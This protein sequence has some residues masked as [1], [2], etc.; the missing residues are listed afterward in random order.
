MNL[1]SGLVQYHPALADLMVDIDAVTQHPDNNNN[2]DVDQ[3][4]TSIEVNG[5][6]RPIYAQRATKYIVAG[7]TTWE[8]CK[9]LGAQLIPVIWLDVDDIAAL[10]ILLADNKIAAL[11]VPDDAATLALLDLLVEHDSLVG[12][13]WAEKDRLALMALAQVP[14]AYEPVASWPV[15]TVRVPP[16]VKAAYLA[17]T[18][19][20]VGDRER[21]EMMMRLAGWDGH[22]P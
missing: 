7:N 20:A 1:T 16:A 17:M 19:I 11:A 10:R 22:A 12:T 2:G 4:A 13:G 14:V 3:V 5:M 9:N 18:E 15:I 21:F 6:Y 8:A